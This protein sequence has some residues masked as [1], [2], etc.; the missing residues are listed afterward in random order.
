MPVEGYSGTD[1]IQELIKKSKIKAV[2][3]FSVPVSKEDIV[4]I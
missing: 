2:L 4:Y 1:A 3:P